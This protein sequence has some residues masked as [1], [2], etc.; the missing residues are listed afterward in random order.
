LKYLKEELKG[1]CLP[2]DENKLMVWFNLKK[3][4]ENK[5]LPK[6]VATLSSSKVIKS[7]TP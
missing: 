4:R 2:H 1:V 7:H 6:T 3:H 5:A